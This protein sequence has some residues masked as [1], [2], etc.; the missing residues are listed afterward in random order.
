MGKLN[1][2]KGENCVAKAKAQLAKGFPQTAGD[3]YLT[4]QRLVLE[5]D[6]FAS[7]GFGKRWEV[8]L[9]RIR[10]VEKL[11]RFEGG[12]YVGA[13]GKK[14]AIHLDD[15]SVHTFSFYLGSDID[16]FADILTTQLQQNG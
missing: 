2:Q 1:L 8:S 12:T 11:G 5:P 3:F 13:A 14:I 7:L 4:N 16:T 6:Q 15:S 9:H 10:K